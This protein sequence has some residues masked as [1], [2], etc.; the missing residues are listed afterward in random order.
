MTAPKRNENRSVP[1]EGQTRVSPHEPMQHDAA[2]IFLHLPSRS[3]ASQAGIFPVDSRLSPSVS[4][5]PP[6]F[7]RRFPSF[8]PAHVLQPS[9]SPCDGVHIH[10]VLWVSIEA[11]RQELQV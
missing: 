11:M 9:L 3:N 7:P 6:A 1:D 5:V 2:S 4:Q 10:L 8:G